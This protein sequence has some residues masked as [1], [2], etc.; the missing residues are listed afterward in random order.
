MT[1]AY[2]SACPDAPGGPIH[3]SYPDSD[4]VML[5][6]FPPR[7]NGGAPLLNYCIEMSDKKDTWSEVSLVH[8][9]VAMFKI[10]NLSPEK[11]YFFRVSARNVAGYSSPLMS[12]IFKH[13]PVLR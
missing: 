7:S 5:S 12:K 2:I 3:F 11:Q 4:S 9:D 1:T 13:R 6:W 10:D 8:G